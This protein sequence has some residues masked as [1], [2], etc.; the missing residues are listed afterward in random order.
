MFRFE[1]RIML[2]KRVETSSGVRF[3]QKTASH[4]LFAKLENESSF[5]QAVQVST[6]IRSLMH[7]QIPCLHSQRMRTPASE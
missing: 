1:A 6:G 3:E 5:Q 7:L 2:E 4:Q